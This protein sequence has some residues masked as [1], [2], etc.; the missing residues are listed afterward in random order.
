MT[1]ELTN[2]LWQSTLFAAAVGLLVRGFRRNRANVRFWLWFS[3]SAKFVLPFALLMS[4]GSRLDWAPAATRIA[5]RMTTPSVP[6]AIV[7]IS[8]PFTGTLQPPPFRG[9]G[10]DWVAIAIFGVWAVGV[11]GIALVRIR[12]WRRI[13]AALRA[14]SP[15]DIPA[16][17]E[18]RSTPGL[19]EPGVVGVLRPIL[20][21]PAGIGESLTPAQLQAVL[22]HERCHARRRDNL[23]ASIHMVIE[24]I[25]W[26]HPAVWWIGG[27]LLEERERACDE[28]VL[29]LGGEP[30][31][32]AEGILNVCKLY[33]ESPLVCVSGV[34][35][36]NLEKRIEA[37]M[38]N[39]SVFQ[40]S[41]AKKAV[42]AVA[43]ISALAVPVAIGIINAP[44]VRAQTAPAGT[45]KFET[46]SIQPGCAPSGMGEQRKSKDG[47]RKTGAP[48]PP[49]PGSLNLNC[50]TVASMIHAAYGTFAGGRPLAEG[51]PLHYIDSVPISGGPAWIYT[52]QYQI[53]AKAQ[54]DPGQEMMR[55]PMMQA[56]LE[57]RFQVK[58][59]R[60]TR[61]VPAYA[62]TVAAGG[63]KMQPFRGDCVADFVLPPLP[64]GQKHCWE[65]GGG[66]RK[67]ADF[68]PHFAPD[69]VVKDLDGFALWL[70]VITDRPVANKTGL[71]GKYFMDFVFAP[72]Q[73]TP[74]ALARL[75]IMARRN[76]GDAGAAAAPSNPPGPSIFTALQQEL[77]L[78]LEPSTSPR[79]FILIDRA[80]RPTAN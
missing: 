28:E 49:S 41:F 78:K 54:G 52:D 75:A 26:F 15:V 38:T 35:G 20:L 29:S 30:R 3:A 19:L 14:S 42:L 33:A 31:V 69:T 63:P 51:D 80:E 24:A 46:V 1:G 43:G 6:S 9:S 59:R 25:F 17:L 37:I 22:E 58:I 16:R 11:A 5:T 74:G 27:R 76:G 79:D 10:R 36:S 45:P 65:I 2:H 4:L 32:Y 47:A 13:R 55:G 21:V 64:P 68:T 40:L 73:S 8:R 53:K 66:Q 48:A 61:N 60:E 70:Y 71:T 44:R 23:W 34:T 67:E 72:D 77:G 50:S 56:L 57:E 7:E 39:R 62:L 18:V 12:G